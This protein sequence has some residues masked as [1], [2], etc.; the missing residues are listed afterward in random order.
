MALAAAV[1]LV[2]GAIHLRAQTKT[3]AG[4]L[5]PVPLTVAM[6]DTISGKG[7]VTAVLDGN[8]LTIAGT[9]SGLRS[10]ATTARL[11]L[12]PRGV[13]GPAIADLTVSRSPSGNI[14]G[15]VA[16]SDREREALDKSALYIQIQ[17]EKA[18][19]GNLWGWLLPQEVKR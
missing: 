1:L 2:A 5:S 18:P 3:Y 11:H 7:S 6:Q 8:R 14:N 4:R 16:L 17:S 13:R 15:V 19:E 9:F 10:P 12:A